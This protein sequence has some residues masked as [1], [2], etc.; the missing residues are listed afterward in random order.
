MNYSFNSYNLFYLKIF[1]FKLE[2]LQIIELLI[3]NVLVKLT[4][5]KI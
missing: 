5:S 2:E 3:S 4:F 1:L